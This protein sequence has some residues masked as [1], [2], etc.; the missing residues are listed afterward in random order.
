MTREM[1]EIKKKTSL[2]KKLGQYQRPCSAKYVLTIVIEVV[3]R[4]P[5]GEKL[6]LQMDNFI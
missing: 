5:K 1:R 2:R 4:E 6:D 3:R